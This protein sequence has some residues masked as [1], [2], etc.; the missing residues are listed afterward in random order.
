MMFSML[1]RNQYLNGFPV[2]F[3]RPI[4]EQLLGTLIG[5]LNKAVLIGHDMSVRGRLKD[6]ANHDGRSVYSDQEVFQAAW[7]IPEL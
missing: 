1:A 5:A 2:K 3:A 6:V 7:L 4:T